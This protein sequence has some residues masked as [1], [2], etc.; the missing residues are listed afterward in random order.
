LF[1]LEGRGELI[2]NAFTNPHRVGLTEFIGIGEIPSTRRCTDVIN[3]PL[4]SC[5]FICYYAGCHTGSRTLPAF[6]EQKG[7]K[8]IRVATR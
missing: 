2:F 3:K 6:H 7:T 5:S 1:V 4:I 8:Q